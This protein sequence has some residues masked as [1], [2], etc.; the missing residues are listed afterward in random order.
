VIIVG[1]NTLGRELAHRLHACGTYVVAVDTSP[2]HLENLP[3]DCLEGDASSPPVL[4]D[5]GLERAALLV[6]TLHITDTNELLAY[7]A[8]A[9][10]V[11]CAIHAPDVRRTDKLVELGASYVMAPKV[12]SLKAQRDLLDDLGLLEATP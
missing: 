8:R 4:E 10:G 12:D 2:A 7:R 11:H 5:A 1:M 9:A 6:S 3:C